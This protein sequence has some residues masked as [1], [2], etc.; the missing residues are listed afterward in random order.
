[1]TTPTTILQPPQRSPLIQPTPQTVLIQSIP[2][3]PSNIPVN[4][5]SITS[6]SIASKDE[7][8]DDPHETL[9]EYK[10]EYDDNHPP[11]DYP[12]TYPEDI[13]LDDIP[14]EDVH[15]SVRFDPAIAEQE[16]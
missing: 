14:E 10:H 1:M 6:T 5:T 16:N 15:P 4:Q 12:A 9:Q 3:R 11:S 2:S 7:I 13:S 8:S